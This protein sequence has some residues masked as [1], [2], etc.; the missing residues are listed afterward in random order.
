M[1]RVFNESQG[2]QAKQAH[3]GLVPADGGLLIDSES[4]VGYPSGFE[5]RHHIAKMLR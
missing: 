3:E 4:P 2:W 5:G 1:R